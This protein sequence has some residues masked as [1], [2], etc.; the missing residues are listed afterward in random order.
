MAPS[1]PLKSGVTVGPGGGVEA[2][3]DQACSIDWF[4]NSVLQKL[5]ELCRA[6]PMKSDLARP[7]SW[8]IQSGGVGISER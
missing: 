5:S 1:V 7:F 3:T 8:S 2:S 6:L 4:Q